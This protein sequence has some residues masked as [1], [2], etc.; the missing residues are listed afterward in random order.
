MFGRRLDNVIKACH[1]ACAG[2]ARLSVHPL[3]L[4]PLDLLDHVDC[5]RP[6][7]VLQIY[8]RSILQKHSPLTVV[9]IQ[10]R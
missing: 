7:L 1:E 5:H 3:D 10:D 4:T 9:V 8:L 6:S 2:P